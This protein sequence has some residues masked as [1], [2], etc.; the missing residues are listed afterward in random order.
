MKLL[1][2][3]Q[4]RLVEQQADASSL[5][6]AEMMENAGRC[7]S[8]IIEDEYGYLSEQGILALVGK[9]N[10]GGD[11]LV[12]LTHLAENGWRCSAYLAADRS[13][14]PLVARLLAAGCKLIHAGDDPDPQSLADALASHPLFLDG[15]LGTGIQ[16]PLRGKLQA[17]LSTLQLL[18]SN[19]DSP[20]VI[21]AVDCPSGLDCDT[22]ATAP[23]NPPS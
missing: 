3:S 17:I 11:A 5:S 2:V 15:L 19:L 4:M 16:L 12:A 1:T 22:G 20:P 6:Y 9:G 13:D 10:N 18:L 14:D 23:R 7:L 21:I 8:E